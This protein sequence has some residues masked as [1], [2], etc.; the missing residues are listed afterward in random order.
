MSFRERWKIAGTIA[1]EIRFYGLLEANPSNLSRI[2]EKPE[3][4]VKQI[5]RSATWNAVLTGFII[6]MIGFLMV[7]S[8]LFLG[9]PGE[10]ELN[11]AISLGIFLGLGFVIIFFVNLTSATGF[12]NAGAMLLPATLPLGRSDLEGLMTLVFVRI[13]VAPFVLL[14]TIF[15]II[16]SFAFGIVTGIFV[17]GALATTLILALGALIRAAGWF[18]RKSQSGDE[19]AFSVIIRV[20]A[21]IGM[22][23]G[24]VMAYSAM[25]FVPYIVE[26]IIF[27]TT[28]F[29]P[30]F[31][32]VFALIFP[33]SFGFVGAILTYG[34]VFSLP[35][36]TIA[37]AASIIYVF[38]GVRSYRSSGRILRS[39]A[40]GGAPMA[41]ATI[42]KPID[43][44]ISSSI[45]AFFAIPLINLLKSFICMPSGI[46]PSY[47][48]IIFLAISL[49]GIT[50]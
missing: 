19:S 49:S 10:L 37:I 31:L 23:L 39:L 14:L 11:F 46:P 35:T 48:L 32:S 1:Q 20:G 8:V 24:I 42:A 26:F 9:I 30:E 25:N 27:V 18:H 3:H 33:F 29:S 12:F 15:P 40:L 36:N 5:K 16:T 2:K 22:T 17:L 43:L 21:G 6:I 38:L 44:R 45:P 50:T 28:A 7:A 34:P 47:F 4:V 13:F 41:V